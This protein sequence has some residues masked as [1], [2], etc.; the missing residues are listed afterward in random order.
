MSYSSLRSLKKENSKKKTKQ[1]IRRLIIGDDVFSVIHALRFSDSSLLVERKLNLKDLIPRGIATLRGREN[2]DF[3]KE[4]YAEAIGQEHQQVASF[5]KEG[6]LKE[7]G[8]RT[9]S[10]PLLKG[11]DFYVAP[12]VEV[13]W[14]ALFSCLG[15][16]NLFQKISLLEKKIIG[17]RK[18]ESQNVESDVNWAVDCASGESYECQDLYF[19][20]PPSTLIDLMQDKA[21]FSSDFIQWCESMRSSPVLNH[22]WFFSKP[23]S[24][25]VETIFLPFSYT[26]EWGHAMVEFSIGKNGTQEARMTCF[27][28]DDEIKEEDLRKK[29]RLYKRNLEKIFS[30]VAKFSGQEFLSFD[31]HGASVLVDDSS[32]QAC[33][34]TAPHLYFIGNHAAFV[35]QACSLSHIARGLQQ[36]KN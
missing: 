11:E 29:I 35:D 36:L 3:F 31:A 9:K 25:R 7:F 4:N 18:I 30:D 27:I 21:P 20:H 8:G 15:D 24:D 10:G 17:I 5:V 2:V 12:R 6:K 22:H 33:C 1:Y 19:S 16:E 28:A 13:D 14:F 26:H 23:V 34:K 32:Y